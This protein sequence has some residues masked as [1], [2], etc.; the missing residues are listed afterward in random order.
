MTILDEIISYKKEEVKRLK[1]VTPL[2]QI[3][4]PAA[5]NSLVK[6]LQ[7]DI[8]RS[9]HL[10]C[11]VKKASPSKGIIR[12]NF[13]P[14]EIAEKYEQG[15]A[16]AI[17]VLTDEKYF[18]GQ[19]DYLR[20]I[21]KVVSL[22]VLRKDFIIDEYQII[23]SKIWQADIILLI[24][25]VLDKIQLIDYIAL[26]AELKMDV[27]LEF[28]EETELNKIPAD[29]N[30]V[31]FGVNNRDLHNFSVD[32]NKSL[33]LKKQLP[34]DAPAISESGI[35]TNDDCKRLFDAGFCGAL[36]GETLMRSD[37]IESEIRKLKRG[38]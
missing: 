14:V 15:G 12:E 13:N 29:Y 10:I 37:N 17:S 9:F 2:S 23:E 11:E 24:A 34:P 32:I 33:I 35:K 8:G 21:K 36:I 28:S 19:A 1:S 27:L 30:N 6:Q 16:S 7:T 22:P 31:I 26:A 25:K 18:M 5:N 4:S 20:K 3:S 38:L